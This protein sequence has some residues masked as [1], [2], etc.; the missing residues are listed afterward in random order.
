MKTRL[1]YLLVIFFL[2]PFVSFAPKEAGEWLTKS[3]SSFTIHY[4]NAD[5]NNIDVYTKLV[6]TGI[7]RVQQFFNAKYKSNFDVFVYY[8]RTSLDSKWQKDWN[9]PGFKSECWMVASGVATKLDMI[10]PKQW[11]TESC[12]HKYEDNIATQ[13]L[14]TH[15]LVHVFHG[16]Y[17]KSSDFSD[18]DNI[19]WFVEGLATYVSGQCNCKRITD[20]QKAISE[21]KIPSSLND[22]WKGNMRYGLSGA[23]VLYIDKTYG[24]EKLQQLLPLNKKQDILAALDISENDLLQNWKKFIADY[25]CSS[26]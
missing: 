4:T 23:M 16:Q 1:R 20:I 24:R 9:M 18:V 12:E 6:T 17:N 10:S 2:F 21:N 11:N 13:Q 22:F 7:Q 15:E 19:D 3:Y 8:N 5:E 26:K 14:I 25:S